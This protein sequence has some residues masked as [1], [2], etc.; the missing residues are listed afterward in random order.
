MQTESVQIQSF[1]LAKLVEGEQTIKSLQ[2]TIDDL[3]RQGSDTDQRAIVEH[4]A[5]EIKHLARVVLETETASKDK[6]NEIEHLKQS[7]FTTSECVQKKI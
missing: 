4:Q 1:L 5:A 2:Q 7:V 6:D 3:K